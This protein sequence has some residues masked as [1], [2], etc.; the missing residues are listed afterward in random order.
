MASAILRR[1]LL[2]SACLACALTFAVAQEA[3]RAHPLT[4]LPPAGEISTGHFFPDFPTKQFIAGQPVKVVVGIR[5]EAAEKY[6]ISAIMGSLN[7]AQDFRAY[8]WNFTQQVYFQ[9][10]EPSKELSVEYTFLPPKD[11]P[12]ND[13]QV[14]LTVFYEAADGF[15]STTFFNQTITVNEK[16][17]LIDWKLIFLY[18][19]FIGLVAA[20]GYYVWST[21]KDVPLVKSMVGKKKSVKTDDTR[22]FNN[23]EWVAGT[24]VAAFYNKKTAPA[25]AGAKKAQ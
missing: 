6:N 15:K 18:V 8:Y 22:T 1:S 12:A 7:N 17:Q 4:N 23:D 19:I 25:K 13:Y 21:V 10:V 11:L 20:G 24:P 16:P 14:A 9:V 2:L 5:N 3:P